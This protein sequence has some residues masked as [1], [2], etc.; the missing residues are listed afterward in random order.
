MPFDL[1]TKCITV[2][3]TLNEKLVSAPTVVT[4]NWSLSLEIMCD[5][6]DYVIRA[7]LGQRHDKYFQPIYYTS[8]TLTDA[9]KNYITTENE[10]LAMVY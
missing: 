1:I 3:N 2:F 10:L 6:N 9:Q 8:K 5:A 4:P 7:V